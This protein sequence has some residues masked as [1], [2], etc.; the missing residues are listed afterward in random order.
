MN[1]ADRVTAG[2]MSDVGQVRGHNEDACLVDTGRGLFVVSDGM[3]G[4][5]AGELASEIVVK[6]LPQMIGDGLA[7]CEKTS[8][9]A[10]R[11]VLRDAVTELNRQLHEQSAHQAGLKGMGATVA[12]VLIRKRWAH[13]THMGDSR[14]Y[15]WRAGGLEQ[16]TADHSIVGILLRDGEITPEQAETHPAKGSLSRYV[17]MG[18]DVYP[19]VRTITLKKGDRLLLCSDGLT[20]MVPDSEIATILA[21]NDDPRQACEALVA[22]ANQTGGKDNITAVVVNWP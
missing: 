12:L 6:A 22:A 16:L 9:R 19:D 13:I 17:G 18:G 11:R 21:G 10:I 1:E 14:V 2:W 5:Q 3:G 4:A 8:A 15:L 7:R 20:G